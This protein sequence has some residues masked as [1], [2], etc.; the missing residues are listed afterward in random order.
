ML[1]GPPLGAGTKVAVD[2]LPAFSPGSQGRE[3]GG[4]EPREEARLWG[5]RGEPGL[6]PLGVHSEWFCFVLFLRER[7]TLPEMR[8]QSEPLTFFHVVLQLERKEPFCFLQWKAAPLPQGSL[9]PGKE[10]QSQGSPGCMQGI[11]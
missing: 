2:R 7:K 1:E 4:S 8:P 3:L 11:G 6:R 10:C 5:G 9:K